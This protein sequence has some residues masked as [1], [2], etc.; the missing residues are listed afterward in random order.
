MDDGSG[1]SGMGSYRI[2][3]DGSVGGGSLFEALKASGSSSVK[4][5]A[6]SDKGGSGTSGAVS[7]SGVGKVA[8]TNWSSSKKELFK[9]HL[10]KVC[11]RKKLYH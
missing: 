3:S 7:L 4:D 5:N 1:W 6:G 9:N 11:I 2:G 10:I 8:T